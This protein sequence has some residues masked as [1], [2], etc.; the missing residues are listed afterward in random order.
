[1]K[2]EIFNMYVTK[3]IE[4]FRI[5]RDQLFTKSK[6]R[7][8]VDARFLLYYLCKKRGMRICYIQEYMEMNNYKIDHPT[9]IHGIREMTKRVNEDDD[10]LRIVND[11]E[12]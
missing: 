2:Q 1:M 9:I 6:K 7:E 5:T 11:I 4:R 12:K 3:V 8:F 10:Y